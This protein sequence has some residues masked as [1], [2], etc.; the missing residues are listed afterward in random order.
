MVVLV[1][2][3][4]SKNLVQTLQDGLQSDPHRHRPILMYMK[5]CNFQVWTSLLRHERHQ[6]KH[7][8]RDSIVSEGSVAV[9]LILIGF[10]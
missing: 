1:L 4:I 6:I 7:M 9:G 2:L 8:Q 10:K 5:A 3:C